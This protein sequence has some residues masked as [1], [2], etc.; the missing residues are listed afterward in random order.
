[1]SQAA[2]SEI[3]KGQKRHSDE[4]REKYVHAKDAVVDLAAEARRAAADYAKD[5]KHNA[6]EWAQEK[7]AKL[8]DGASD[9]NDAVVGYVRRNPYT[10]IGIAAAAGVILG[11]ALRR[12]S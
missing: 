3:E 1:M 8:A 11:L 6:G 12:Q 7:G 10:A 9:M 2:I 5:I 4:L